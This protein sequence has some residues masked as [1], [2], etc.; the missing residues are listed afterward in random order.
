MYIKEKTW[1]DRLLNLHPIEK[2]F[3]VMFADKGLPSFSKLFLYGLD[4]DFLM[5]EVLI[6]ACMDRAN[7]MPNDL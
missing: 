5:F 6:L 4:F 1:W 2:R 7:S 3:P